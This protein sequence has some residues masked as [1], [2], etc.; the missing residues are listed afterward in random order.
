M[1]GGMRVSRHGHH[2]PRHFE[3]LCFANYL[4]E[5]NPDNPEC[6]IEQDMPAVTRKVI[7]R[8]QQ[9]LL[10]I[11]KPQWGKMNAA[12]MFCHCNVAYA[13]TYQPEQF[14]APGTIKKFFSWKP[15]LKKSLQDKA[16]Q[17]ELP[18]CSDFLIADERRSWKE[19]KADRK[20]ATDNNS[21]ESFWRKGISHL[22]NDQRRM[23]Q[24]L[25]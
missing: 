24:S 14:K 18:Y 20:S 4:L 11:Q 1:S 13:Y 17:Q 9:Q 25:L 22:E 6:V 23:E 10:V 21:G 5:R 19:I 8:I 3:F 2:A 16:L 7:G 12:Q 15:F